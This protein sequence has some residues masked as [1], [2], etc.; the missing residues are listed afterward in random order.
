M[1][2]QNRVH[3]QQTTPPPIML[4]TLVQYTNWSPNFLS[5]NNVLIIHTDYKVINRIYTSMDSY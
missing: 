5:N 3:V 1:T 2:I 4:L